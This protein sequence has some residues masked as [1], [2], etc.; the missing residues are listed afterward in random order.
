MG[1]NIWDDD[2]KPYGTFKGPKGSPDE[3]K[4]AFREM[5]DTVD[6]AKEELGKDS[7][8]TILGL[9]LGATIKEI[10]NAWKKL[11]IKYGP[12]KPEENPSLFRKIMAAYKVLMG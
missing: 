10:K 2:Y 4:Q 11:V 9:K 8:L 5:F 12:D 3:W 1:K 7:P 6:E